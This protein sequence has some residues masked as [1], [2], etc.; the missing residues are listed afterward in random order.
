MIMNFETELEFYKKQIKEN[1]QLEDALYTECDLEF[2]EDET[3]KDDLEFLMEGGTCEYEINPF[4]IDGSGGVYAALNHKYI[5]YLTSEGQCGI[6]AKNI[7]DFFV[8]ISNCKMLYDYF[9][10]NVFDNTTSFINKYK[11]VNRQVE[12]LE[13]KK[14][15][16]IFIEKNRFENNPEILY[17]IL[18][19][20]VITEPSFIIEPTLDEYGYSDDLF[21]TQQRYIHQLR[22]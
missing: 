1:V 11:E 18:K 9:R 10:E 14:I 6:I 3:L 21:G 2:A 13:N 8:L 15:I 12:S 17:H 7:K 16:D 4:A 19:E 22:E 20:A 5:G